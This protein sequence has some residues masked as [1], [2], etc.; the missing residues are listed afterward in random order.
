M[1]TGLTGSKTSGDQNPEVKI[2]LDISE[3]YPKKT[4][5]D[6]SEYKYCVPCI[7]A[8]TYSLRNRLRIATYIAIF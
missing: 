3:S 8:T 1:R 2:K 5:P 7:T 4:K 6:W